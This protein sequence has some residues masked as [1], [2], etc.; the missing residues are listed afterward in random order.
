M[1]NQLPLLNFNK[2]QG[3]KYN[4]YEGEDMCIKMGRGYSR[5]IQSLYHFFFKM[6]VVFLGFGVKQN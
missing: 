4:F 1:L 6:K 5:L 2:L 3:R